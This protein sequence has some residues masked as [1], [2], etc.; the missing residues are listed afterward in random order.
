VLK[1]ITQAVLGVG[2]PFSQLP[3]WTPALTKKAVTKKVPKSLLD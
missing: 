1:A 3:N 2:G